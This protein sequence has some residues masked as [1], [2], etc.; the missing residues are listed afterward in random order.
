MGRAGCRG[1]AAVGRVVRSSSMEA[2]EENDG[3][4]GFVGFG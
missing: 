3:V 1:L 2:L 4:L